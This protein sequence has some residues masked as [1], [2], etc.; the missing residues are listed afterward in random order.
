MPPA[1]IRKSKIRRIWKLRRVI[2]TIN[3][4]RVLG[5]PN[6]GQSFGRGMYG[7]EA[8]G[9]KLWS[10]VLGRR[11]CEEKKQKSWWMC[12]FLPPPG[13]HHFGCPHGRYPQI[14]EIRNFFEEVQFFS[15]IKIL[16][17]VSIF[18]ASGTASFRVAAWPVPSDFGN[19]LV[20]MQNMHKVEI[21]KSWWMCW[22]VLP[23]RTEPSRTE[24]SQSEPSRAEPH[25]RAGL[26]HPNTR[27]PASGGLLC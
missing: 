13:R 5:Y 7:P 26:I 9:V 23:N 12:R 18:A 16:E 8:T 11:K 24:P 14:C 27:S 15:K 2:K 10:S 22:I 1:K 19:S 21:V 6:P 4:L 20:L 25:R 17:D 3:V